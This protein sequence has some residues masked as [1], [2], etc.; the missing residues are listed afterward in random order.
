MVAEN[1]SIP[2]TLRLP[3]GPAN[4]ERGPV[5]R[6]V[7]IS[8]DP[9]AVWEAITDDAALSAWFG[10]VVQVEPRIR[11]PVRFTW[12]DGTERRGVVIAVDPARRLAFRWR[13][14]SAGSSADTSTVLFELEADGGRTHLLVTETPGLLA[15]PGRTEHAGISP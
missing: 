3:T 5:R 12:P 11:G 8:A 15:E 10:A 4:E 7:T 1:R 13:D 9:R 6:E 2:A 14:V